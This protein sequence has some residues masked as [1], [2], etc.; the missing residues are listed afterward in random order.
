MLRL[1]SS[2]WEHFYL[3]SPLTIEL[4]SFLGHTQHHLP[5]NPEARFTNTS[6]KSAPE[7][8]SVLYWAP[9]Q[10]SIYQSGMRKTTLIRYSVTDFILKPRS[11]CIW[12]LLEF[13]QYVL[14]KQVLSSL[15]GK[16]IM[17]TDFWKCFCWMLY[18]LMGLFLGQKKIQVGDDSQWTGTSQRWMRERIYC[19]YN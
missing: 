10:A 4:L 16:I 14:Y 5:N 11:F 8:T 7:K 2:Q 19:L 3:Y 6:T 13:M 1:L 9:R 17:V 18:K 12:H 15:E